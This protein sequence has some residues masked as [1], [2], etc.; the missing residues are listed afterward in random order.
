MLTGTIEFVEAIRLQSEMYQNGV[1]AVHGHDFETRAVEFK[2]RIGE[3]IFYRL[4]KRPEGCGLN[5]PDAKEHVV[6]GVHST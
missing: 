6:P 2:I 1:S 3:D 5:C 4:Y